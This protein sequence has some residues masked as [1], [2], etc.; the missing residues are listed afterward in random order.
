MFPVLFVYV[1]LVSFTPVDRS[2]V[3]KCMLRIVFCSVQPSVS[4][5][6]SKEESVQTSSPS[7]V[8]TLMFLLTQ[9]G[10]T[11]EQQRVVNS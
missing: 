2:S 11:M 10:Y 6:S 1:N 8:D 7:S 4:L 9:F 5:W 3:H